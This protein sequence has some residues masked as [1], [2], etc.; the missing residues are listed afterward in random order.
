MA[1]ILGMTPDGLG[2]MRD[3]RGW[4]VGIQF[5]SSA[6]TEKYS[7]QVYAHI[8]IAVKLFRPL[9]RLVN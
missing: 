1:R 2:R 5:S 3:Q 6:V 4:G 7:V 9:D 8:L